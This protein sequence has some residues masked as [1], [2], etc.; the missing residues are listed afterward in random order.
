M[1]FGIHSSCIFVCVY[2]L[3]APYIRS[4]LPHTL[5]FAAPPSI[6]PYHNWNW[7]KIMDCY[8]FHEEDLI[9]VK[10]ELKCCCCCCE[11]TKTGRK[12]TEFNHLFA[13]IYRRKS[14]FYPLWQNVQDKCWWTTE[15]N[16]FTM[17]WFSPIFGP[18]EKWYWEWRDE[19]A[20]DM[21]GGNEA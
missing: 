14:G 16:R 5:P 21:A 17:K 15:I 7:T 13:Y 19:N 2:V 6:Q 4:S 20:V 8:C 10:T 3:M 11:H 1:P 12:Q 9:L 18:S